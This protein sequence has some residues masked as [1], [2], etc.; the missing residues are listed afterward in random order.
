M[1]KK[2][3]SVYVIFVYVL[4]GKMGKVPKTKRQKY[5]MNETIV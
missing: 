4:Q 1:T 3:L 5:R 2:I